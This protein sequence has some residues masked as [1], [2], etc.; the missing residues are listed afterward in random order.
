M[1]FSGLRF[2]KRYK[3]CGVK[4]G[5]KGLEEFW[6]SFGFTLVELS[7]NAHDEVHIPNAG[8][9]ETFLGFNHTGFPLH[10]LKNLI[11]LAFQQ[12]PS[13]PSK[14]WAIRTPNNFN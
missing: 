14:Y 10:F 3:L 9:S 11:I 7:R 4:L 6:N 5:K 8:I 12:S 13:N 1:D 2:N